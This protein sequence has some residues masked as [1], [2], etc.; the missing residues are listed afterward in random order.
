MTVLKTNSE[1]AADFMV[2][3]GYVGSIED[4]YFYV[5]RSH[6]TKNENKFSFF[7][8]A[9]NFE[10]SWWRLNSKHW[11]QTFCTA[12]LRDCDKVD[13]NGKPIYNK[14]SNCVATPMVHADIDLMKNFG[15]DGQEFYDTLKTKIPASCYVRSSAKGCQLYFKLD[16]P[17]VWNGNKTKWETEVGD[18]F[19][20]ICY[21]LGG[22]KMVVRCQSLMRLPGSANVKKA[23][24]DGVMVTSEWTEN[25][26]TLQSLA[27]RFPTNP[28]IVPFAIRSALIQALDQC[29]I[30]KAS[31]GRHAF[32]M[33]LAGTLRRGKQKPE[34][35]DD[36]GK[37]TPR[38]GGIDKKSVE[39]LIKYLVKHYNYHDESDLMSTVE[40]TFSRGPEESMATLYSE[41]PACHRLVEDIVEQWVML[42]LWYVNKWYKGR[43]ATWTPELSPTGEELEKYETI[44]KSI[45]VDGERSGMID[46]V[47]FTTKEGQTFYVGSGKKA[48]GGMFSN[49]DLRITGYLLKQET[50]RK[51]MVGT[52]MCQG[53]IIEVELDTDTVKNSADLCKAK[54]WPATATVLAP[55]LW[56]HYKAWLVQLAAVDKLATRKEAAYYGFLDIRTKKPTLL[57]PEIEHDSYLWRDYGTGKDTALDD[58]WTTE[59]DTETVVQYLE[60]LK[61]NLPGVHEDKYMYAALGWLCACPISSFIREESEGFPILMISGMPGIGKSTLIEKLSPHFGVPEV[62]A[63]TITLAA[64]RNYLSSNNI[65]PLIIDEFRAANLQKATALEDIIRSAWHAGP[66]SLSSGGHNVSSFYTAP[67]CLLG[68]NS[69]TDEASLERTVSITLNRKHMDRLRADPELCE[70]GLKKIKWLKKSRNR[71]I[72][73]RLLVKWVSENY[74]S[75]P[76]IINVAYEAL[77]KHI[78]GLK[79][80]QRT[81]YMAV[82]A[83]LVLLIQIYKEYGVVPDAWLASKTFLPAILQA[84][85]NLNRNKTRDIITMQELFT[86][87]DRGIC[88]QIINNRSSQGYTYVFDL[89]HADRYIYFDAQRWYAMMQDNGGKMS[90]P[91]QDPYAFFALLEDR[92]RQGDSPIISFN[93]DTQYFEKNC[94]KVDLDKVRDA[95]SIN[96]RNWISE[97][98]DEF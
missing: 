72:L 38:Y 22:D 77:D 36:D 95:Y 37:P 58:M 67:F 39:S 46:G 94:V 13:E 63:F 81:S 76:D 28:N 30:M 4:A 83:G 19:A 35:M 87:T 5:Y 7:T 21:H 93:E 54:N 71:G 26:Y 73:G 32:F 3:G 84:D 97:R 79:E 49:F 24:G 43:I 62:R 31:G 6:P 16:T 47:S 12:L 29:G 9:E 61:E 55:Q 86:V 10:T 11:S 50:K 34:G 45:T 53:D 91:L 92:A 2:K 98:E 51:V 25:V 15:L 60:E 59:D 85:P 57:L 69:I 75:I 48:E 56:P 42:K 1:M 8:T 88:N 70:V 64:T 82:I 52:L 27:D 78:T 23:Y 74:E 65:V 66:M 96:V 44:V 41:W 20:N 40:T 17:Y 14:E 90:V 89:D 18:I 68:Q 33:A 80:R